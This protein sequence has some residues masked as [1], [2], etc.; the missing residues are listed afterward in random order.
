MSAQEDMQK[1]HEIALTI[2]NI[3]GPNIGTPLG[4]AAL[5]QATAL[6][7]LA[8]AETQ[9]FAVAY[10]EAQAKAI[11]TT[12]ANHRHIVVQHLNTEE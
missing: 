12:V 8:V 11:M 1:A 7:I 4:G 5:A 10:A 2:L 6:Q 3:L 9:Q